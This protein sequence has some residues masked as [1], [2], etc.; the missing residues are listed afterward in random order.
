GSAF[1]VPLARG[2]RG[3]GAGAA[4]AEGGGVGRRRRCG[5]GGVCRQVC[6]AASPGARHRSEWDRPRRR[7]L[8]R[9]GPPPRVRHR[10]LGRPARRQRLGEACVEDGAADAAPDRPGP[11]AARGRSDAEEGGQ[12]QLAQVHLERGRQLLLGRHQRQLRGAAFP[13]RG[14]GPVHRGVREDIHWPGYRRR[15]LAGRPREPRLW[16]PPLYRGVGPGHRLHVD[17]ATPVDRPL[18]DA[19][20]VLERHG[21]LPRGRAR[22]LNRVSRSFGQHFRR[23][24]LRLGPGAQHLR[25]QAQPPRRIVRP[26]GSRVPGGLPR[27]FRAALGGS[28]DQAR[29]AEALLAKSKAEWQVVVTH[30]PTSYGTVFWKDMS[31]RHGID[32]IVSGHHH[33]QQVRYHDE[34]SEGEDTLGPTAWIVSGGGGG[35]VSESNPHE[36]GH[37][38]QYGFIDLSFTAEEK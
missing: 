35:I 22:F 30:F 12:R 13:V 5:R 15:P 19:S 25:C 6:Q 17:Q 37:D 38:D 8:R 18:G 28:G 23:C 2:A 21:A 32:L 27:L 20:P 16:R 4:G 3:D 26:P 14:D 9:R 24:G 33:Y 31:L 11:A 10:R 7:L 1:Q 34:N 36:D 29:W